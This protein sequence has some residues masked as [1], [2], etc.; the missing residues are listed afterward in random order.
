VEPLKPGRAGKSS[1]L[2]SGVGCFAGPTVR[3]PRAGKSAMSNEENESAVIIDMFISAE[4]DGACEM[5]D[6]GV[7]MTEEENGRGTEDPDE[8]RDDT[9]GAMVFASDLRGSLDTMPVGLKPV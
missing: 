3:D 1:G 9:L 7:E 8:L 6:I 5:V 2:N 4:E